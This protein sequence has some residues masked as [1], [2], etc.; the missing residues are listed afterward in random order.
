MI[1][2]MDE[3]HG[4]S[5]KT[6]TKSGKR[7]RYYPEYLVKVRLKDVFQNGEWKLIC[8]LYGVCNKV[9]SRD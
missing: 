8:G 9:R 1:W 2:P 5:I 4:F 6:L 7:G 3:R